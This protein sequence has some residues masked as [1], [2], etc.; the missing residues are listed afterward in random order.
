MFDL[1]PTALKASVRNYY[2]TLTLEYTSLYEDSISSAEDRVMELFSKA[3]L[4]RNSDPDNILDLGCGTGLGFRMLTPTRYLGIDLSPKMIER[5]KELNPS[6]QFLVG[7][8]ESM[9][10]PANYFDNVISYYGSLSHSVDVRAAIDRIHHCLVPG[11]RFVAMFYSRNSLHNVS[12]AVLHFNREYLRTL[13]P[14]AIRNFHKAEP[15]PVPAYFYTSDELR[16]LFADFDGVQVRG[17]NI[18]PEVPVLKKLFGLSD[19]L[20]SRY[21]ELEFNTLGR[22]MPNLGYSLVVTGE[23]P[24]AAA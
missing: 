7:D 11:G 23:K 10:W 24:A 5:A 1:S 9:Q 15:K 2:D 22:I 16:Q 12:N 18:L 17:L 8:F 14:Y 4:K 19:H 21:L 3:S 20:A 6:A 13:R